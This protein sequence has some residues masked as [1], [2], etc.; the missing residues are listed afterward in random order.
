MTLALQESERPYLAADE[1][2]NQVRRYSMV[3][4]AFRSP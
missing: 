2:E 4:M 1:V 3:F